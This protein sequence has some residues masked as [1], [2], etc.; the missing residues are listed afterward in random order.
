MDNKESVQPGPINPENQSQEHSDGPQQNE[1]FHAAESRVAVSSKTA[2]SQNRPSELPEDAEPEVELTTKQWWL[3][4]GPVVFILVALVVVLFRF[5]DATGLLAIGKVA[6]GLGL[7]VFVHELGHFLVAKWCGV[8]VQVFSL[9][10]GPA[11]PGCSF[12]WGETVYKISLF[13]LGGYVQMLGQVD[14]TEESDGS[15]DDPRSYR[16]KNV[17]QRMA[18]ISA[19]VIMNG[20]MAL[21]CFA[22]VYQIPGKKV[23]PAVVS[24][25]HSGSPSAKI[26]LP[27]GAQITKIGDVEKKNLTFVDLVFAVAPAHNEEM[28]LEYVVYDDEGKAQVFKTKITPIRRQGDLKAMIGMATPARLQLIPGEASEEDGWPTPTVRNTPARDPIDGKFAFG[29]W[30]VGTS[31]PKD[32]SK[33]I[34]LPDDPRSPNENQKDYFVF[35]RRMIQLQGKEVIIRVKGEDGETRD[36][37]VAPSFRKPTGLIM[38]PGEITM[39]R[40]NSPAAGK[41]EVR[42]ETHQ[43]DQLEY[44][45]VTYP[46]GKSI[47]FVTKEPNNEAK[48]EKIAARDQAVKEMMAMGL[49]GN[50]IGG[51]VGAG[52]LKKTINQLNAEIPTIPDRVRLDPIRLPHELRAW[53]DKMRQAKRPKNEWNVKLKLRR[54]DPE[55]ENKYSFHEVELAWDDSWRF[56]LVGSLAD[57]GKPS[58]APQP[59]PELGLAYEV[60]TTVAEIDKKWAEKTKAT[61]LQKGDVIEQIN[62]HYE[63]MKGEPQ[64]SGWQEVSTD[65]WASVV[66]L[67][68]SVPAYGMLD[69]VEFKVNRSGQDELETVTIYPEQDKSWPD[70]FTGNHYWRGIVLMADH[71]VVQ[72][73]DTF[74]AIGMGLRDAYR[75][76][77]QAF[78]G[79]LS[80]ATQRIGAKAISGPVGIARLAYDQARIDTWQFVWFI[81]MIS[82]HIAVLNFLPIPVLDGG[83]MVFLLYELIRGKPASER[84]RTWA[85]VAGLLL[86]L[87]LVVFAFWVDIERIITGGY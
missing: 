46:G 55:A 44:V 33:V 54:H 64:E 67:L 28:P 6:V 75:Q 36:V 63:D 78:E 29:D 65:G 32:P 66:W 81:A 31:D 80:I 82:I 47:R 1:Q 62:I 72:A 10:F 69:R 7:V 5:F 39:V 27:S 23:I 84:I 9:G 15:E 34:P 50:P 20:I 73:D 17:F 43:G 12:K 14:G 30:I 40:D 51:A 11:I 45:Q 79:I 74:E 4:N 87:C 56:N 16:N 13:P 2:Q 86:I 37:R 42:N 19:G 8:Y 60:K 53:A 24:T 68:Q 26:G 57:R 21:V 25:V 58:N 77:Q 3:Q 52:L 70:D 41:V 48:Q 76:V 83:H 35:V 85:T 59:I 22:L 18:I 71:R 49:P 61:Q 38:E